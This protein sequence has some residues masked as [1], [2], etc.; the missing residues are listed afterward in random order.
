[1]WI[2]ILT[3]CKLAGI[4][5]TGIAGI[6]S[7]LSE[8]HRGTFRKWVSQLA[9]K[10]YSDN[11]ERAQAVVSKVSNTIKKEAC[12]GWAIFGVVIALVSQSVESLKAYHDD[13]ESRKR[14]EN[15]LQTAQ[16]SLDYLE[17]L[18]AR[19]KSAIFP[20]APDKSKAGKRYDCYQ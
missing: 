20:I 19:L 13:Q 3:V 15:Q 10:L 8:E 18:T 5:I 17:R 12:V 4:S 6:V 7:Q 11:E 16:Q 14:T 9:V 1:M 2:P